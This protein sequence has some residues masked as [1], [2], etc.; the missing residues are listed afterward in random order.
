MMQVRGVRRASERVRVP[1]TLKPLG[2]NRAARTGM[3]LGK[4]QWAEMLRLTFGTVRGA[5]EGLDAAKLTWQDPGDPTKRHKSI[6][7]EVNHICGA[8]R[9]WLGETGFRAR[10]SPPAVEGATVAGLLAGLDAAQRQ[11]IDSLDERSDADHLFG[12]GRVLL[13]ALYHRANIVDL[14]IRQEPEWQAPDGERS[15]P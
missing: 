4:E 14:R 13:H 10:F 7:G 5:I 3:S 9:Y 11:W 12:L 8:A 1:L 6:A 15:L 2:G